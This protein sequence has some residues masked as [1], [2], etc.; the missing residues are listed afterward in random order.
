MFVVVFYLCLCALCGVFAHVF[1]FAPVPV[2]AVPVPVFV[3]PRV[4]MWVC[5]CVILLVRA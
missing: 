2:F 1:V 4:M 5:A 3:L